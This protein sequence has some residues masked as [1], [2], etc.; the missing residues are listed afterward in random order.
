VCL[1]LSH[2]KNSR[3]LRLLFTIEEKETYCRGKTDLHRGKRDLLL[4]QK[5]PTNAP[6]KETP[7]CP[8]PESA[9]APAMPP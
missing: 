9:E 2:S 1:H 8:N 4:R 6:G 7:E 3:V 5:R